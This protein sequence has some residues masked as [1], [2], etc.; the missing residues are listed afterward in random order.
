M[1]DDIDVELLKTMRSR[2]PLRFWRWAQKIA[3][4][5]SAAIARLEAAERDRFT[6][7]PAEVVVSPKPVES[8]VAVE[9]K[10]VETT[11]RERQPFLFER[12]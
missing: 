9:A 3:I 2:H 6:N 11:P 7:K 4:E 8:S 10:P 1:I 5:R 12:D